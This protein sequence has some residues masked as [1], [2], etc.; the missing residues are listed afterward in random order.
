[1]GRRAGFSINS[2]L[3]QREG[4]VAAEGEGKPAFENSG[5]SYLELAGAMED[6]RED[7]KKQENPGGRE[8][9]KMS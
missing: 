5:I 1:M 2:L 6:E 3:A 8:I 4:R 7:A 9:S